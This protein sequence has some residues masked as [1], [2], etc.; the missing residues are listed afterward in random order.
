MRPSDLFLKD[1]L[2]RVSE[3]AVLRTANHFREVMVVI[4][5]MTTT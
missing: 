2:A 4:M 5:M 3:L 1:C